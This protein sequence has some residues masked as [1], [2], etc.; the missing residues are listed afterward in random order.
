M[1]EYY[2]SKGRYKT[3]E[4]NI[5]TKP[6]QLWENIRNRCEYLPFKNESRFG[7]YIET[8]S[9]AEWKDF[10]NFAEW[11]N[12][13]VS[14]GYYHE[15]WQLDKDLLVKGNN[16]YSPEYCVFL[17]EVVNNILNI[18][19][20]T[21]GELPAGLS[22]RENRE[23]IDVRFLCKNPE[24]NVRV[25]LPTSEN[26]IQKGFLLYKAAREGYV[27]ALADEYKDSLDPKAYIALKHY[28]VNIDD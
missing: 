27:K 20:R 6:C 26:N 16:I 18:K 25:Y 5:K 17:P 9:C 21:R 7:K 11:F 15:G 13:V 24:F 14:S 19:S 28:E 12:S 4:G 22:Y 8:D 23:K 1:T 3:R 2:N 10:Q